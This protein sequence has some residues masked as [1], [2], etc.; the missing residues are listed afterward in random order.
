MTALVIGMRACSRGS[1]E[2]DVRLEA[3]RLIQ[4]V[5]GYIENYAARDRYFE[6]AHDEAFRRSYMVGLRASQDTFLN[7]QYVGY[8][9]GVMVQLAK[10]ESDAVS[11]DLLEEFAKENLVRLM[12]VD[13]L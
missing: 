8:L 12:E 6:R 1:T 13:G 3:Q 10:G 7:D 5:P 2:K 11:A 9:F 4:G